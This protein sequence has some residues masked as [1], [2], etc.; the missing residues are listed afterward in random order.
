M[1]GPNVT[2]PKIADEH[3]RAILGCNRNGLQ[4]AQRP[5]IAE[6]AN[7]VFGPAHFKQASADFVRA[8]SNFFNDGRERN[9]VGA[10]FF[11]IEIDLILANESA[12]GGYLG[13]ARNGFELVAQ[14]PVLK[15]AQI[16][17]AVL[18]AVVHERVFIDPSCSGCVW[19]DH[20][21]HA[22]RADAR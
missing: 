19:P 14:I 20:G 5:Q 18:M 6:A 22:L 4:I 1:S 15:A 12:D 9:T 16:R 13:D 7:H 10:K 11:G 17:Q 3:W 2:V 21:M 8:G